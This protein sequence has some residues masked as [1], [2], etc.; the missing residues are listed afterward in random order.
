MPVSLLIVTL[1]TYKSFSNV[2]LFIFTHPISFLI[3]ALRADEPLRHISITIHAS[4]ISLFVS[5]F[6][7]ETLSVIE[8]TIVAPPACFFVTAFANKTFGYIPPVGRVASSPAS[9]HCVSSWIAD[10]AGCA[11]PVSLSVVE[12]NPFLTPFLQFWQ[13]HSIQYILIIT[14]IYDL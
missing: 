1:W 9:L 3:V 6:T 5:T 4:P 8:V 14:N 13:F 2:V 12:T 11:G 7:N 10:M